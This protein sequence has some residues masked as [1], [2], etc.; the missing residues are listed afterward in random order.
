MAIQEH[1]NDEITV[2]YDPD[3]CIH[4][5]ECVRGLHNV[6][7]IKKRPWINIGGA[8]ADQIKATIGKCP[9]GALSYEIPGGK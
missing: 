9:S 5:G 7:D 4:A 2:R 1:Q 3:V 8:P 6:F